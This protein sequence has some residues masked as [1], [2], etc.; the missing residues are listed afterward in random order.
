MGY[1]WVEVNKSGGDGLGKSAVDAT[2]L[3]VLS[4]SSNGATIQLASPK[5]PPLRVLYPLTL[6]NGRPRSFQQA[7]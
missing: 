6:D 2:S 7:N 3:T 1:G 5:E 4:A